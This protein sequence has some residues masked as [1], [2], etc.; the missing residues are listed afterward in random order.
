MLKMNY[1]HETGE[2]ALT[3]LVDFNQS[4]DDEKLCKEFGITDDEY[5]V[6]RS[7]IPTYYEDVQ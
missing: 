3:P 7:V 4:W 1:H 5:A 6:I 2:L